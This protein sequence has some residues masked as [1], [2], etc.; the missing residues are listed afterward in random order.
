MNSYI[1]ITFQDFI[2][3]YQTIYNEIF[4]DESIDRNSIVLDNVEY[5]K[6]C[7]NYQNYIDI[8]KTYCPDKVEF[9]GYGYHY[10]PNSGFNVMVNIYPLKNHIHIDNYT[11]ILNPG[12]FRERGGE[13]FIHIDT[14]IPRLF[15]NNDE[16]H[17]NADIVEFTRLIYHL[18]EQFFNEDNAFYMTIL[19]INTIFDNGIQRLFESRHYPRFAQ[20]IP[21]RYSIY[22]SSSYMYDIES[23]MENK[24][25]FM[26]EILGRI[27]RFSEQEKIKDLFTGKIKTVEIED[28]NLILQYLYEISVY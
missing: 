16:E 19:I 5:F 17:Y 9:S 6:T 14:V 25:I 22:N 20:Y 26:S 1:T 7:G 23:H 18:F 10:K 21:K 24:T 15:I 2:R 3:I 12:I 27:E 11:M 28:R 4:S 13:D 8:E